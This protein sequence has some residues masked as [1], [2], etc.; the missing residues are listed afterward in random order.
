M[1]RRLAAL[2]RAHGVATWYEDWRHRRVEVAPET[3]VAVL[4]L[5]GV[6]ASGPAAVADAL[7]AVD[8]RDPHALPPTVVLTAGATRALPGPA[9]VLLEDGGTRRVD[10]EL[11]ADLPLGW[12]RLDCAGREVPLVVVPPRLPEPPATW[13]WMLQLYALCSERSWGMGD[14][15]DLADFADWAGRGGAG[16]VLLNPL[17]APAPVH[18]VASSPYS[19]ASRR[20]VNPLY[21]RVADTPAYRAADAATRAVVD[22]LRPDRS[23]LVDYDAVWAAKRHALELLR[24]PGEP[25]DADADADADP[26]LTAFATWCALAERHGDDWRR[27][28]AELRRP[29]T[30][31]V[32]AER[33]RLADRVAF[34]AWLQGLCDAQLTAAADAA[35]AAGMPVGVVHDLAVG[36][37]PGGADGWQLA[38]VL[39]E[40]VRV[41]APPDDFNQ[42]GQDWGLAAWRP[43]RLAET[44]YAAYRDMLR[45]VL[46]H[47][48][49]LRVD[50]VAG[51]WRLWWVPPGAGAAEGTYVHYDAEA[52]LG[53]LALEAQRAGAVVVGED[54]GTVE[55][56]VTRGLRE[57][58]MLG[59]TVLWFA[60]DDD[61]RFQPPA[62]WPRTALATVS[63]HD[64]P[65]APGFLSGEHV[66]VRAELKLL[67]T[68]VRTERERAEADR[69]ELLAM[70]RVE[71]LLPSDG[72]G[73]DDDEVVAALYAALAASPTLLLAASL[74]DVLGEVRQPNMPGTVDEYP[75][76]RLPLP[77]SLAEIRADPRVARIAELLRAAR[78]RVSR[79]PSA[80]PGPARS[81]P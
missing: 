77:A 55:P 80:G 68:D 60:R 33:D 45:R 58:G 79:P 9:T 50:H 26:D 75:N 5:L 53:I 69:R 24:P 78:P 65:T 17:H 3:V 62:R 48:G 42:L 20:F 22:A 61:G 34:H 43:D 23:D 37:D 70:L 32:A 38:D 72:E 28:P 52:M 51:L 18:P 74:Y 1:D 76:W 27:W 15:G 73:A 16:L 81:R 31:E 25:F 46:R 67:A 4:G 7:A 63:T 41:G 40:G 44:G 56:A 59:S 29:D 12:H 47:A 2:A 11:P 13:G 8:A 10:G 57:R 39:A 71:G 36:I 35:R 19:P 64:L 21:L 49:G 66:R 14:L 6:D 30:P 54:L